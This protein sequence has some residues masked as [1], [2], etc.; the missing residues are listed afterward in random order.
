MA[1]PKLCFTGAVACQKEEKERRCVYPLRL[2]LRVRD[3]TGAAEPV[4]RSAAAQKVA[5]KM[6]QKMA[7]EASREEGLRRTPN[8]SLLLLAMLRCCEDDVPVT[9]GG[10]THRRVSELVE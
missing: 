1:A 3:L 10:H 4:T 5:Q 9:G 2:F 6:A 8:V 7:L